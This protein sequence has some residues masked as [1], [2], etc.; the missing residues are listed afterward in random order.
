MSPT[1][2]RVAAGKRS[3]L[4]Y[5]SRSSITQMS[6]PTSEAS[7]ATACPTC[8]PPTS[9]IVTRGSA[10]RYA[11]PCRVAGFGRDARGRRWSVI[12]V[13]TLCR[14]VG[15]ADRSGRP[16]GVPLPTTHGVCL[17]LSAARKATGAPA[18]SKR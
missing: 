6:K 3:E 2:R 11:T 4:T 17:L 10:G 15:P 7:R 1:S 14:S 13:G 12:V 5:R 8:P 18:A 16:D 9:R